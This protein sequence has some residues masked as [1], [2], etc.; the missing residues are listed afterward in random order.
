MFE[1]SYIKFFQTRLENSLC[2]CSTPIA[3]LLNPYYISYLVLFFCQVY[4]ADTEASTNH[5]EIPQ[6]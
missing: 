3:H 6:R 4:T 5:Q 1:F 2:F